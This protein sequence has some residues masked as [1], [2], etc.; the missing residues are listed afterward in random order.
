MLLVS[1]NDINEKGLKHYETLK[2][3]VLDVLTWNFG[4]EKAVSCLYNTILVQCYLY[5]FNRCLII[6]RHFILLN[7]F[8]Q[9]LGT[10]NERVIKRFFELMN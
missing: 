4:E 3:V 5:K 9:S 10:I 6:D 1:V 7:L 8:F 2:N